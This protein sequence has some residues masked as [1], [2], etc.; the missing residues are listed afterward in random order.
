LEFEF[1]SPNHKPPRAG[2]GHRRL[3]AGIGHRRAH[4]LADIYSGRSLHFYFFREAS[5]MDNFTIAVLITAA[6]FVL[7]LI[8]GFWSGILR[9]G[10]EPPSEHRGDGSDT[11]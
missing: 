3:V 10:G 4:Q 7:L 6:P 5:K 1:H 9:L 8:Y 11:V 2:H